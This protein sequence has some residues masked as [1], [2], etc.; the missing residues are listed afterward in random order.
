MLLSA[1]KRGTG[2]PDRWTWHVNVLSWHFI[3]SA[4]LYG[5]DVL[6][7]CLHLPLPASLRLR[8]CLPIS[9]SCFTSHR[10]RPLNMMRKLPRH[11]HKNAFFI[12]MNRQKTNSS[13]NWG[14]NYS[15]QGMRIV[16]GIMHK[17]LFHSFHPSQCALYGYELFIYGKCLL[18]LQL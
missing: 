4:P 18:A 15:W 8:F 1:G 12:T 16:E 14:G 7:C 10:N 9:C 6:V 17:A 3:T 5:R 11:K 13:S 2:Q